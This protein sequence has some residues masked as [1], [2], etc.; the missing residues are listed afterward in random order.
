MRLRQ[1]PTSR[2]TAE[3][4]RRSAER[5]RERGG[6]VPVGGRW[7][8]AGG[9]ESAPARRQGITRTTTSPPTR[10]TTT[11]VGPA[12]QERMRAASPCQHLV[13]LDSGHSPFYAAPAVL[14]DHLSAPAA[15][16]V[17]AAP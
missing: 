3:L 14:A 16:V 17:A 2:P 13:E 15:T 1:R 11:A 7:P 6:P 8:G 5:R 12:L 4:E 10:S 9:D